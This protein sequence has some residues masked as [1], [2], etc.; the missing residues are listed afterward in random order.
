MGAMNRVDW[1]REKVVTQRVRHL[2]RFELGTPYPEVVERVARLVR[3]LPGVWGQP[4][5]CELVVDATGVGRPVV[6]LLRREGM[7]CGLRPVMVTAGAAESSSDGYF[8]VPKRDLITGLQ[9][10]VQSGELKVVKGLRHADTLMK[11]MAEMRVRVSGAGEQF[12]CWRNGAH[13][14]LV[15]A[16]ALAGWGARKWTP[17]DLCGR[18]RLI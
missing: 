7:G 12:G 10:M 17:G 14:D 11:E 1:S 9:A 5:R 15:F 3:S 8:G 18:R 4:A 6:D 2:E 13:D 16:V